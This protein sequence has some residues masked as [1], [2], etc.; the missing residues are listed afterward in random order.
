M[1]SHE[2]QVRC[3]NR[4]EPRRGRRRAGNAPAKAA[5]FVCL[6]KNP[7]GG[8]KDAG[9]A[10]AATNYALS[11]VLPHNLRMRVW[12]LRAF[13]S[14]TE[15]EAQPFMQMLAYDL[16]RVPQPQ[17]AACDAVDTAFVW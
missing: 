4:A 15:R 1:F 8:P 2:A 3:Q 5:L 13:W 14:Q 9:S 17:Q 6:K 16:I 10:G 7:H 11:H 12:Q